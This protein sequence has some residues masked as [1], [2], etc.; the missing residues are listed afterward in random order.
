MRVLE[1][2]SHALRDV[3]IIIRLIK[4]LVLSEGIFQR[5][6]HVVQ[7]GTTLTTLK[8]ERLREQS[9]TETILRASK[10]SASR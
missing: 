3:R 4:L 9:T 10:K 5:V 8:D 6:R 7:N 1:D 2:F